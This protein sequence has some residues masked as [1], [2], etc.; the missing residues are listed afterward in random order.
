V[1][2]GRDGRLLLLGKV[3]LFVFAWLFVSWIFVCCVRY[4]YHSACLLAS[5]YIHMYTLYISMEIPS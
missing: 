2:A 1:R 3:R 5:V 4:T